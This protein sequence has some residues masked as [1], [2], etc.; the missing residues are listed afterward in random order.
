MGVGAQPRGDKLSTCFACNFDLRYARQQSIVSYDEQASAWHLG[1]CSALRSEG[2]TVSPKL[3]LLD[4]F[5][6]THHLCSWLVSRLKTVHLREHVLDSMG[7]ADV[8]LRPGRIPFET[9]SLEERHHL[10]QIVSWLMVDL[11]PRLHDAWRCKAIRYNHLK[12]DFEWAPAWYVG[13]VER[14]SDWRNSGNLI[15]PSLT[16]SQT[17]E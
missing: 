16:S 5:D 6:V 4:V 11:K 13:I 9:R 8:P 15:L 12:K 17:S 7:V 1:L 3:P 2:R 14:F 10:L